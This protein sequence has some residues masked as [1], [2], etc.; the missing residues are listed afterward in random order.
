MPD[1]LHIPSTEN[2]QHRQL[3]NGIHEL[4]LMT[5]S[6][7]TVDDWMRALYTI[8]EQTPPAIPIFTLVDVT[9]GMQPLAYVSFQMQL[10]VK[11][12]RNDERAQ[13]KMALIYKDNF[14]TRLVDAAIV[15]T[16]GRDRGRVRLFSYDQRS[17]A[18]AW[19]LS[20]DL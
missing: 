17:A 18:E 15:Q 8:F 7:Q 20:K 6:R 19:L 12:Y 3:E 13:G 14:L 4:T 11:R 16:A 1:T 5:P 10:F 2:C 9:S